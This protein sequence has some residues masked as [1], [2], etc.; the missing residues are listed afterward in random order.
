MDVKPDSP[1]TPTCSA[2]RSLITGCETEAQKS[3]YQS[4]QVGPPRL[5]LIAMHNIALQKERLMLTVSFR[6]STDLEPKAI[7]LSK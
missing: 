5:W 7:S 2:T 4:W 1:S 6:H 3:T